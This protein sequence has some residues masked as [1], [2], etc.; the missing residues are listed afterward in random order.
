M[1]DR[2]RLSGIGGIGYHGVF[3]EER[4]DGQR[5]IVDVVVEFDLRRPGRSDELGDT[6][7]YGDVAKG[8]LARIEG[9]PHD[10]IER[11]AEVVAADVLA[12]PG[13]QAV[14]VVVHKPHAP[15]GVGL[16][17]IAVEIRRERG[18]PVVIG[19]GSNLG[20]RMRLLTDA[21]EALA[22]LPRFTLT[23]VSPLVES[24]PIG[25]PDQP[26]YYNG[27][28]LGGYAGSPAALLRALHAIEHTLGRTREVRWGART[29]DLDLVQFGQPGSDRERLSD[30]PALLLP[31]PGA[32]E[33]AFVLLPWSRLDPDATLR[34]GPSVSDPVVR[35]ADRLA[36]LDT[37][38]MRP[39]PQWSPAW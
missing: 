2:I 7:D 38:G 17:D 28:V 13:V 36:G 31:H 27:V 34:T 12:R 21:V 16:D 30:D 4:R 1:T 37:R 24:D 22:D 15:V 39:G 20:D 26:H 14:D 8:V 3:P 11:L 23:G 10:L 18:T 9:E 25:G 19:L 6:V 5:F 29:L 32:I 33:R 35:V